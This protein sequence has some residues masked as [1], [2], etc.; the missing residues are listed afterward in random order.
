MH[1]VFSQDLLFGSYGV[2]FH[3]QNNEEK[4]LTGSGICQPQFPVRK[5][6][7]EAK[8][9]LLLREENDEDSLC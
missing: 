8:L 5:A 3:Q 9:Y 6:A 7:K 1:S 4:D 2:I